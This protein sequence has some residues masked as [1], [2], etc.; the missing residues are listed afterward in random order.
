MALW[1]YFKAVGKHWWALLS[2][3]VFT[4]M[5]VYAVATQRTST[6]IVWATFFAAFFLLLVAG[7]LA[8]KDEHEKVVS[9]QEQVDVGRPK[10]TIHFPNQLAL[11]QMRV[12]NHGQ[13]PAFDVFMS[14]IIQGH[15]C[16]A[17]SRRESVG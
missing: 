1:L 9:A 4:L 3:A 17:K 15:C 5:G 8:W 2:C 12:Y 11:Y 13:R 6:W 10:L 7:F 14:V 16:P